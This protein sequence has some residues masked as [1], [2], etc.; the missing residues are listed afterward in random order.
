MLKVFLG[1]SLFAAMVVNPPSADSGEVEFDGQ[2]P[3]ART[4]ASHVFACR[5]FEVG[6]RYRQRDSAG[7]AAGTSRS[8]RLDLLDIRFGS[9]TLSAE[10]VRRGRALFAALAAVEGVSVTCYGQDIWIVV[11]GIS[12]RAW[13]DFVAGRQALL[14][15]RISA[16]MRVSGRGVESINIPE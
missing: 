7:E 8:R 6:I 4:D 12:R 1:W 3:P 14:L 16:S 13:D 11:R 10:E 15:P 2:Y 9:K 5:T